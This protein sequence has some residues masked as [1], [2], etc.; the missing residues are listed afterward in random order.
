MSAGAF[1]YHQYTADDASV[2]QILIQPE[3][4]TLWSALG[5]T[6]PGGAS[7]KPLAIVGGSKRRRGI[8]HARTVTIKSPTPPTGYKPDSPIT[9]P[10]P[11]ID[12]YSGLPNV[13]E[14]LGESYLG[15][16][17]WVVVSKSPEVYR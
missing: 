17:T 6:D 5:Y 11:E 14:N 9:L 13:G 10:I 12:V 2:H 4:Y 3:T 16:S 1:A 15:V 7:T 8:L